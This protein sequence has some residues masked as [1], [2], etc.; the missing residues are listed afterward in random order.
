MRLTS[1]SGDV[2]LGSAI[3]V[4][5]DVQPRSTSLTAAASTSFSV[6]NRCSAPLAYAGTTSRWPPSSLASGWLTILPRMS[7]S[8]VSIAD[9][10]SM[11]MPPGPQWLPAA[12][13]FS[14]E[15]SMFL[16][17]SP[18]INCPRSC[19]ACPSAFVSAP[20]KNVTPM[21]SM[22]SAVVILHTTI[23][24]CPCIGL[25]SASGS[26]A[27]CTTTCDLTRAIFMGCLLGC[28]D[29][30][31]PMMHP[32]LGKRHPCAERSP[33]GAIHSLV[34]RTSCPWHGDPGSFPAQKYLGEQRS[35]RRHPLKHHSS[36]RT[37]DL[38]MAPAGSMLRPGNQ[39]VEWIAVGH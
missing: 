31:S 1:M 28:A 20:P 17:S 18:M 15:R 8:A 36:G 32:S 9:S 11:K 30:V 2:G 29:P 19:T 26:S 39:K 16:G 7:H 6:R 14:S 38:R 35:H 13:I 3:C 25:A 21:P 10:A 34:S 24:R 37:P 27:V 22:P 5:I 23:S 33:A 4:F 12:R